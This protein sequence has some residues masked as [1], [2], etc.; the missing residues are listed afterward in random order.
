M[1]G[2]TLKGMSWMADEPFIKS[3]VLMAPYWLWRAIGGT[4]MLLA[5]FVFFYNLVDMLL[6]GKATP[7]VT[8]PQ[9]LI[10]QAVPQAH[11]VLEHI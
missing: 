7:Q 6:G 2:G 10:K 1:I 8:L 3:V 11:D 9:A 5:H 4:F